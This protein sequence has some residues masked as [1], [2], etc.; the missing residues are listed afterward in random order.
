MKERKKIGSEQI[1]CKAFGRGILGAFCYVKVCVCVYWERVGGSGIL[2]CHRS[3]WFERMCGQ[4]RDILGSA[5][6]VFSL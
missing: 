5:W 3:L 4:V 2:G 1:I 6:V